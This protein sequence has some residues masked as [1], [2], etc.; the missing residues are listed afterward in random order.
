MNRD[1]GTP[2]GMT[3]RQAYDLLRWLYR[4]ALSRSFV[5][6]P[7]ELGVVD[8]RDDFDVAATSRRRPQRGEEPAR[9]ALILRYQPRTS[10][11]RPPSSIPAGPANR[12]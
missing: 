11:Y 2:T 1:A 12:G 10:D 7:I 8:D 5:F 6:G 4:E 3:L 9:R